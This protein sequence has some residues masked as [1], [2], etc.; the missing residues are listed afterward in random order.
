MP[1]IRRVNFEDRGNVWEQLTGLGDD[2]RSTKTL[3]PTHQA[4]MLVSLIGSDAMDVRDMLRELHEDLYNPD[5]DQPIISD[6]ELETLYPEAKEWP[7]LHRGLISHFGSVKGFLVDRVTGANEHELRA[8]RPNKEPAS[9]E[10][11]KEKWR[12]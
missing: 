11:G 8:E 7:E 6:E 2:K 1:R 4:A 12:S 5:G 10:G 9:I 3:I